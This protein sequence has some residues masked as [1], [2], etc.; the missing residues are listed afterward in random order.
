MSIRKLRAAVG[1]AAV[2][3][4]LTL[5]SYSALAGSSA[6]GYR[7]ALQRICEGQR[8]LV[9]RTDDTISC[10]NILPSEHR[11]VV[12]EVA[13]HVCEELL[14]SDFTAG[15]SFGGSDGS[16]GSIITWSCGP[17]VTPIY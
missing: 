13:D 11:S 16:D 5:V 15:P 3:A 2:V 17:G 4:P 7:D 12:L 14:D 10:E 9:V 1:I 8:G 6:D